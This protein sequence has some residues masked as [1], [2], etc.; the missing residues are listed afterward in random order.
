MNPGRP[1]GAAPARIGRYEII[2][3][4]GKGAMGV[5][6]S[7][8]DEVMDRVV[9]IKVMMADLEGEPDTRTRF[10]RE[11]QA[12]GRLLHPNI[13][14]IFDMG[15]EEGRIYM[16]MELLRGHTLAEFLRQ[17]G[18]PLERKLDLMVQTCEG[19]G[20]AHAGGIV[21]RD[22][23]PGNLFVLH[24]GSLKILDFGVARLASSTM[25]AS[26]FIIGTPDYM[27]PEQA[28]GGDIDPR[29]DIFSAAAVFY[30]MLSGRKPFAARDLPTVLRKVQVEP[31][32]PL[33]EHEA[34]V[35]LARLV[36]KSLSKDPAHRHQSMADLASDLSRFRRHYDAE[37]RQAAVAARERY[38]AIQ[39]LA[40]ERG[41]AGATLGLG[42]CEEPPAAA[43]LRDEHPTF[44]ERAPELLLVPFTRS[45][46]EEIAGRL[47]AEHEALEDAVEPLRRAADAFEAAE[48]ALAA[49]GADAAAT[50]LDEATADLP[51]TPPVRDLRS[52][53]EEAVAAERAR[54]ARLEALAD[55]ARAA[56]ASEEWQAVLAVCAEASEAP[57]GSE[58]DA[59]RLRAQE[60]LDRAAREQARARQRALDRAQRAIQER[61]FDSAEQELEQARQ[62][63]AP[64]ADVRRL[65]AL[66]AD[67]RRA[68]AAEAALAK[69][70]A[71]AISLA[72]AEF[73]V[74]HRDAALAALR[75]CLASETG[76]PGVQRELTRLEGEIRRL[77]EAERR[78]AEAEARERAKRERIERERRE[79]EEETVAVSSPSPRDEEDT[80]NG[81]PA[82]RWVVHLLGR[83]AGRLR[84]LGRR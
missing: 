45:E 53:C 23:K 1:T 7:A 44:V 41:K 51:D 15:E 32:A 28:R 17:P 38:D 16:V 42:P 47:A 33:T 84:D 52:R 27:S 62:A 57:A 40:R 68:S 5:V 49:G 77:E 60:A 25:T 58:F 39:S 8:R 24:D 22:I 81:A 74:G 21:H 64:D 65:A 54:R 12:A 67:G 69:R 4:I 76:A 35:P 75:D 73:H 55:Q 63:E 50:C 36:M 46:I 79:K 29:S 59:L 82:R 70:A 78:R 18:L 26:G 11:A 10:Y 6:Y 43:S 66:V 48:Q 83:L 9:A 80:V 2:E 37:T 13:I 19:L 72:R 30:Y 14:T 34:P 31:P 61:R 20:A 3:R 56:A 71:E